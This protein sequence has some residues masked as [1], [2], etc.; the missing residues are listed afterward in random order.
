MA[1]QCWSRA[2]H[3]HGTH[4]G[5][6][7]PALLTQTP[8]ALGLS[9]LTGA[10]HFQHRY[11]VGGQEKAHSWPRNW[12]LL[13]R[14]GLPEPLGGGRALGC[15]LQG[16]ALKQEGLSL[17]RGKVR[18]CCGLQTGCLTGGRRGKAGPHGPLLSLSP[19]LTPQ[20][21]PLSQM[22][23]LIL[24]PTALAGSPV[25]PGQALA[26]WSTGSWGLADKGNEV[27]CGCQ[28]FSEKLSWQGR[29]LNKTSQ[30]K[31]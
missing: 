15:G 22:Q 27:P 26:T 25:P 23:S 29:K 9:P 11:Q 2:T 16:V 30:G 20:L 21:Q 3:S 10:P 17:L 7:Y 28:A 19:S 13:W 24:C 14:S 6:S 5:A 4:A 12:Q 8:S 18:P 1:A 31:V